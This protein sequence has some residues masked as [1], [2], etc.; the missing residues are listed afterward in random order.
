M[1]L[2]ANV[3]ILHWVG[4]NVVHHGQCARRSTVVAVRVLESFLA[5]ETH[6]GGETSQNGLGDNVGA[7]DCVLE[8]LHVSGVLDVAG[9]VW[10]L[11]LDFVSG[12]LRTLLARLQWNILQLIF[13][14]LDHFVS[15]FGVLEDTG[16]GAYRLVSKMWCDETCK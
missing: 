9:N 16:S 12:Y 11:A 14:Y 7:C 8:D 6:L 10:G 3:L 15:I 13:N 4:W 1:L 2:V 5:G